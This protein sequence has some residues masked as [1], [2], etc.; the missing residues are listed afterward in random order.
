MQEHAA[1]FSEKLLQVT[2]AFSR[3]RS[4][5]EV[6]RVAVA[7]GVESL[8]AASGILSLVSGDS[9][10]T[11]LIS[12]AG[13][14]SEDVAR[15]R[16]LPI[17]QP[18]PVSDT[19]RNGMP[20]FIES[21]GEYRRRY[22]EL[23]GSL[24][25]RAGTR[26]VVPLFAGK[27]VVGS[28]GFG[29]STWV[30]L[31]T[32]ARS[33]VQALACQCAQA[34]ER[35]RLVDAEQEA[36][37]RLKILADAAEAFNHPAMSTDAVLQ[38]ISHHVAAATGDACVLRLVS[39]G[40]WLEAKAWWASD[41]VA[42]DALARMLAGERLSATDA[43]FA[44][45]VESGRTL[46]VRAAEAEALFCDALDER[47]PA[48]PH[49]QSLIVAPLQLEGRVIGTLSV[50]R[51]RPQAPHGDEDQLLVEGLA[52]R[53]ASA[54]EKARLYEEIVR[55]QRLFEGIADASP[56]M[57]Y[58][59]DLRRGRNV[60]LSRSVGHVLGR[61]PREI[62]TMGDTF[63]SQL[64][65]PDD[66]PGLLEQNARFASLSDSEFVEHQYRMR[67]ADG[68]WRW[69]RSRGRVFSRTQEGEP[70]LVLG[71]ASDAT[72]RVRAEKE[73]EELLAREKQARR[74]A[75][76]ASRAKDEFLAMLGHELRNPLSPIMTAL[77][78]MRLRGGDGHER[79]RTIVERQVQH[80]LRLVDDLLDISRITR[81]KIRLK[82]RLIEL[83]A[84]VGAAIEMASPLLESRR[85]RLEVEVPRSG[86]VVE[87]DPDRLAQVMGNLL[88]NAAKYTEPQGQVEV[89]AS[90]EGHEVVVRI[91][92]SGIGIAPELLPRVFDLFVQGKRALD[93]SQGGLGLGLAIA[94]SLVE[95]HGGSVSAGSEGPGRGSEFIIRLPAAAWAVVPARP[96]PSALLGVG[97]ASAGHRVLVVD[98]NQ[99]AADALA[100]ALLVTG[101]V[102]IAAYDGPS[103]LEAA[104]SARPEAAF[105]DIGLPV[106][107][108][109][110]LARR[111]RDLLGPTIKLVALTGYGQEHD[112]ALSRA[113]GFDEHLVK[114]VDLEHIVGLLENLLPAPETPDPV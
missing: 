37:R 105:L 64:V 73:R 63:Y 15:Y 111:M 7:L 17:A 14:V 66:L 29:F 109:Y 16:R 18:D 60:Y 87:G 88:T 76:T 32:G 23:A 77:D 48:S 69:V 95:L 74:E 50:A 4:A 70:E 9:L 54:I 56:D 78:L 30:P 53:A 89:R 104:A 101:H 80:L 94:R 34:L 51:S 40:G 84:V 44:P 24:R 26:C 46:L 27:E 25:W 85:H 6:G 13:L 91:R 113:A 103:A 33:F 42:C 106:M 21:P 68:S 90:R 5:P 28:L 102:A 57:L 108:G 67:H 58:L 96:S 12:S 98:D 45:V 93:R 11:Q 86:L 75:E 110:E 36:R 1:I 72:E 55:S 83:G 49:L 100:E 107:D 52:S 20:L 112:R 31:E 97:H 41:P 114:P 2:S 92:D 22:P 79:E 61:S 3:S 10:H 62:A 19:V 39:P 82:S 43:R 65:H 81:G 38:A 99:D 59:F 71:V 8:G 35:A 47:H